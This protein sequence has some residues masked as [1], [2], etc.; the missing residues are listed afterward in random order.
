MSR[1]ADKVRSIASITKLM[2]AMIALDYD[3]DL[4]RKLMLSKRVQSHL[5]RQLYTREQLIKAM[6]VKSDNAAA[7]TI[8]EDY[9]GGRSAFI[10]RMN[11]QAELWGM[12]HTNF[13]DPSGL[14]VFNT[15]TAR[16][17]SELM[18]AA[19]G[20][21][22][23]REVS[24]QKHIA[25]ETKYQKK[26]R[27]IN[28]SH[29]SGPLLFAFDNVLVSKTGLT[30][31]AGWCVS[32]VVEQNRQQYIVIVLGSKNKKERLDT[33]KDIRYNH[34]LDTNLRELEISATY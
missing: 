16:D 18:T 30:T 21:W 31:A 23:I 14:G 15:S 34:V 28:L 24:A 11:L 8:A 3:K 26:I 22:L 33:V 12:K 4:S 1:N 5:P 25:F 13:I 17:L 6:L 19:L 29:T 9:P 27:T 2:T 10:A 32:M 20:Y 7:E